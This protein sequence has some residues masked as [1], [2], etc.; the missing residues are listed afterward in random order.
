MT[1]RWFHEPVISHWNWGFR[2]NMMLKNVEKL[3]FIW[4]SVNGTD[5]LIF[6]KLKFLRTLNFGSPYVNDLTSNRI[7]QIDRRTVTCT[8]PTASKLLDFVQSP[9]PAMKKS[10]QSIYVIQRYKMKHTQKK[11]TSTVKSFLQS[12]FYYYIE[13]NQ[14]EEIRRHDKNI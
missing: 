7:C 8:N 10:E 6:S 5:Q 2:W 11:N 1:K 14:W 4:V 12:A 9:R 3:Y 13:I